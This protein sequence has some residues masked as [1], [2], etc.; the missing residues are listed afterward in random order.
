MFLD[1][2]VPASAGGTCGRD[3]FNVPNG[4]WTRETAGTTQAHPLHD[5]C[6][7]HTV[8]EARVVTVG[9]GDAATLVRSG[10]GILALN[11]DAAC[12]T[13]A[14]G[15]TLEQ[16]TTRTV[17]HRANQDATSGQGILTGVGDDGST[18]TLDLRQ[19]AHAG[20][21]HAAL[22]DGIG[23]IP[24]QYTQLTAIRLGTGETNDGAIPAW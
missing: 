20:S 15:V 12:E 3:E 5:H 9:F 21:T 19:I 7:I 1:K 8:E 22:G 4:T 11:L 18:W 23:A 6:T 16:C 10:N 2:P 14:T 13:A 24:R 17:H